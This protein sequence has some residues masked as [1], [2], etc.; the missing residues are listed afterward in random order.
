MYNPILDLRPS[1]LDDLG[2]AA[3]LRAYSERLL[4]GG[5]IVL[6]MDANELAERLPSDHET[7]LYRVYQ[8]ALTNI[9]RHA[10]ATHIG[11]TLACTMRLQR[12]FLRSS[13][14]RDRPR[15]LAIPP[16]SLSLR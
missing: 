8:E 12:A 7:V 1:A 5:G 16:Y 3:A 11:M 10:N 13:F 6:E 9:V 14:L 4:D 2:L 15:H